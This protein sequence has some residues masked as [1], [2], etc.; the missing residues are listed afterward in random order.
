MHTSSPFSIPV[1]LITDFGTSDPYVGQVKGTMLKRVSGISFIDLFHDTPPFAIKTGAWLIDRCQHHMPEEAIWLAVIDPGVGSSRKALLVRQ[2]KRYFIAPDNGLLSAILQERDKRET[3]IRVLDEAKF[4]CS[5][6]TF[7][8]RDLFAQAAIKILQ[9]ENLDQFSSPYQSPIIQPFQ[10]WQKLPQKWH[11][12]ILLIDHYGNLITA[13]PHHC[14]APEQMH[15]AT[16]NH[17]SIQHYSHHFAALP[18][19][20]PGLMH[21]SFETLEVVL[22]QGRA[23]IYFQA[24]IGDTVTIHVAE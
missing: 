2:E 8:G 10:G 17:R 12:E 13:L 14:V 6:Q 16:L 19:Q 18:P 3:E 5:A 20:E 23:D 24:K 21:G 4:P 1:I 7:H 9:G 15:Y 22:N 11:A